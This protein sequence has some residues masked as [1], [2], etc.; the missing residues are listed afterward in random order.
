M[1]QPPMAFFLEQKILFLADKGYNFGNFVLKFGTGKFQLLDHL[2][3]S[4]I[5]IITK[6]K[7][8]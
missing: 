4:V 5:L 8:P 2:N 1:I 6:L 3:I 7:I